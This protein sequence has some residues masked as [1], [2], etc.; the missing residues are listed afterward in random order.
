VAARVNDDAEELRGAVAK[1][2][3]GA[4]D[5]KARVV[6]DQGTTRFRSPVVFRHAAEGP[7][8]SPAQGRAKEKEFPLG[9][10]DAETTT[11]PGT[12]FQKTGKK[13]ACDLFV[14]D[15]WKGTAHAE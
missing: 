8:E 2:P 4:S 11:R 9:G 14:G 13:G 3:H 15:Y 6:P 1:E 5:S 10:G 12:M 7:K